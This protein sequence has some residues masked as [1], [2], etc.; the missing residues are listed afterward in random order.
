MISSLTLIYFWDFLDSSLFTFGSFY[1][2]ASSFFYLESTFELD[3]SLFNDAVYA[4]FFKDL[5]FSFYWVGAPN[6]S[7]FSYFTF[8]GSF[9][10]LT[11]ISTLLVDFDFFIPTGFSS[12]LFCFSLSDLVLMTFLRIGDF[13]FSNLG[14]DCDFF[15]FYISFLISIFSTFFEA[16]SFYLEADCYLTGFYFSTIC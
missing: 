7:Y 9:S 2:L 8:L 15:I 13:Y 12:F 5:L 14:T 1:F 6:L 11:I 4:S 10:V 3:V 16:L